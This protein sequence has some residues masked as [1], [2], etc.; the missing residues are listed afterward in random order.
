MIYRE[1]PIQFHDNNDL[2]QH[3]DHTDNLPDPPTGYENQP[4]APGHLQQDP[5]T[6]PPEPD[7]G[8]EDQPMPE[9]NL[10]A[11][12]EDR[13]TI[14]DIDLDEIQHL[15]NIGHHEDI[16]RSI[17]FIQALRHSTLDDN[18]SPLDP[19]ALEHLQNPPQLQ[20][21]IEDPHVRLAIDTY[22]A[23]EHSAVEAYSNV[24]KAIL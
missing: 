1:S 12:N 11:A 6:P 15:A 24:R 14:E 20:L 9:P 5:L 17:S 16:L 22:L 13:R 21:K 19:D 8:D 23:L 2:Y 4:A 7:P 18:L 3:G 10:P